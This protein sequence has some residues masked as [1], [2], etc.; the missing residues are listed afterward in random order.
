MMTAATVGPC[1]AID[2]ETTGLLP[3]SDR[4]V[5]IGAV[6]F[7][8]DGSETGHFQRLV[9]PGRP[10]NPSAQRIHGISDLDLAGAPPASVVLP[11]FLDWIAEAAPG[12]LLAHHAR[13][14]AGFLGRALALSGLSIPRLE[15]T[16]TLSLARRRLPEARSHRLDALVAMLGLE[17][18]GPAH[19]ALADCHRVRSLWMALD[20]ASGP[21]FGFP[22]FD[23]TVGLAVPIGFEPLLEAIARR[24]RVLISYEGGTRGIAP[25]AVTPRRFL[26]KGG[27]VYLVALCHHAGSQRSFR[28]DRVRSFN[29]LED[30]STPPSL[31]ASSEPVRQI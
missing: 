24:L 5:E 27:Q 17:P 15:L 28:L 13:F 16:D 23:P 29:L 7:E 4:I 20:G 25:R 9:Q 8:A 11:E 1:I 31:P 26:H 6:R 18:S 21:H 2:L 19:R 3:E 22:I 10:M 14:D 30:T 12:R